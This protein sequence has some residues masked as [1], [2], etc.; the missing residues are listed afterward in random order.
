MATRN[1]LSL[2]KLKFKSSNNSPLQQG[3]SIERGL[4]GKCIRQWLGAVAM[5]TRDHAGDVG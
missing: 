2:D 4:H 3:I 1:Y 5:H